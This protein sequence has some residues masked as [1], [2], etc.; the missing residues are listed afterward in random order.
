M[1]GCIL[2][3][4]VL[5]TLV[6]GLVATAYSPVDAV[7]GSA[8]GAEKAAVM[9]IETIKQNYIAGVRLE[10]LRTHNEITK[11][12]AGTP[13]VWLARVDAKEVNMVTNRRDKAAGSTIEIEGRSYNVGGEMGAWA[14]K[15]NPSIRF[16]RDP[17]TNNLVDKSGAAIYADASGRVFYFESDSTLKGFLALGERTTAYGYSE[18]K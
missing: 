7:A 6:A 12:D 1:K 2:K 18:P 15:Q 16:A 13:A 14:L 10:A 8:E 4:I 5:T 11:T 9:K 17:M 3:R